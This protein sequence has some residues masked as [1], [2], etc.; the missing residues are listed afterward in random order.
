MTTKFRLTTAAF[1]LFTGASLVACGAQETKDTKGD[2]KAS[3][4]SKN[5]EAKPVVEMKTSLGTIKIE[6]DREKSPITV[7]NFLLYVEKEHYD[8]TI[9]HRVIDGFMIQGGGFA[10]GETPKEKTT[11]S[12][13]KNEAKKNGL[14][15]TAYTIAMARTMVPDSAT[16]QFF[17]NVKDNTAGLDPHPTDPRREHGYA[18][19]GK[20]IEGKEVVD[21]IKGVKTGRRMLDGRGGKSPSADVPLKDVVIESVRVV[22]QK[23]SKKSSDD[24]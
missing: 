3:A 7:N 5:T 18:V 23:S 9:F 1:A 11:M 17:I 10:K 22:E 20:V 19:F 6:L 21:K 14:K 12:P 13:I 24:K 8:N 15:N 4:T 16:S 2:G